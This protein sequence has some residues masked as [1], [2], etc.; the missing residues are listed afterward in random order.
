[1]EAV[2]DLRMRRADLDA[3]LALAKV[4]LGQVTASDALLREL[5][6]EVEL[7]LDAEDDEAVL[8]AFMT[9]TTPAAPP[10]P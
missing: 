9:R 2:E 6:D 4:P 8:A 7:Y 5:L 10:A 3:K 1:M